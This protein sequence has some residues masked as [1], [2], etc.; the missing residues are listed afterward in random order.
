[1]DSVAHGCLA[2]R[3]LINRKIYIYMHMYVC[4]V[5]GDVGCIHLI[6]LGIFMHGLE[7]SITYSSYGTKSYFST[8]IAPLLFRIFSVTLWRFLKFFVLEFHTVLECL[9]Y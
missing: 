5:G 8:D 3:E 1:M 6:Y 4:E 7:I 9:T 2:F